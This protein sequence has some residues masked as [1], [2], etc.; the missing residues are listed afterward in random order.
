[1][2]VNKRIY[3]HRLPIAFTQSDIDELE[4]ASLEL[5]INRSS[6]ARIAIKK[7]LQ[8]YKVNRFELKQV[9]A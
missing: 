1:M 3:T 5:D 6:L 4:A 2:N 8:D 9:A 7:F